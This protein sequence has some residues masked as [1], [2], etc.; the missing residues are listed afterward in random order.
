MK[1]P[2]KVSLVIVIYLR[3]DA[4]KIPTGYAGPPSIQSF[5]VPGFSLPFEFPEPDYSQIK[6]T[7]VITD[8]RI[9]LYW[10]PEIE[11]MNRK[12]KIIFYNNDFSKRFLIKIEGINEMG[13]IVY[14]K[15]IIE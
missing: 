2:P 1:I 11:I 10:N 5:A 6:D 13:E 4:S 9:T 7:E 8:K 15:Q 3:K 12:A 14:F